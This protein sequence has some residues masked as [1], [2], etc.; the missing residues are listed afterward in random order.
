MSKCYSEGIG[1]RKDIQKAIE[2]IEPFKSVSPINFFDTAIQSDDY[3]LDDL[4]NLLLES[5]NDEK[6]SRLSL[7]DFKKNGPTEENIELM[8]KAVELTKPWAIE[9]IESMFHEDCPKNWKYD[10]YST[11]ANCAPENVRKNVLPKVPV[12]D[13][14]L[15]SV[16]IHATY[17]LE[18]LIKNCE[19]INV[20]VIAAAGTLLGAIRHGGFIPWDDDADVFMFESDVLKLK[21]HLLS[22]NVPFYIYEFNSWGHFYKFA[23]CESSGWVDIFPLE[24]IVQFNGLSKTLKSKVTCENSGYQGITG[25][26]Y[27]STRNSHPAIVAPFIPESDMYPLKQLKFETTTLY[28]PNKPDTFLKLMYGK[29]MDVPSNPRTHFSKEAFDKFKNAKD[30]TITDKCLRPLSVY[31]SPKDRL[32]WFN[33]INKALSIPP[34]GRLTKENEQKAIDSIKRELQSTHKW[35]D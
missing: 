32:D 23:S 25:I 26:T 30:S 28:I 6:Y 11:F 3:D 2:V 24:S 19:Q 13:Q 20:D 8:K 31:K 10:V 18:N 1:V 5:K 35:G 33:K 34:I 17:L 27:Q 16:Q 4:K 15:R 12:I 21:D 22:L 14:N 9:I 29:Y 7:L